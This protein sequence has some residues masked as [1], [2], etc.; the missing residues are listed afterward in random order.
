MRL[1]AATVVLLSFATTASV[2]QDF[3]PGAR[4]QVDIAGYKYQGTFRDYVECSRKGDGRCLRID[5]DHGGTAEVKPRYVSAAPAG[6]AAARDKAVGSVPAGKYS[7]SFF[8]GTLQNVPGFTLGAGGKFSD[9]AGRGTWT[10]ANGVVAFSGGA[11]SGQK[12]KVTGEGRMQV[13]KDNGS[14]GA[15]TCGKSK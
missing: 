4:V 11:W 8:S 1:A 14:P 15:V 5:R 3:A 2:A 7:C 9:H 6:S 12:A 10:F 13:L